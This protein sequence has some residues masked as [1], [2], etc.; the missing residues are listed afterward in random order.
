MKQNNVLF[1]TG[2][3]TNIGKTYAT[4]F[5]ADRLSS[6]GK[7]VITQKL[8]QT[9]CVDSSE[10]IEAHRRLTGSPLIEEDRMGLTCPFIFS[11][12]ASP[13]FAAEIDGRA[14]DCTII[15]RATEALLARGY[16]RVLLEGAGGL[17]VPISKDYLTADFVADRSYPIALVSSGR[18]GSINHTLLNLEICRRRGIAV[19]S[20]I[21]NLYPLTDE[22]IAADT[23]DYL[24]YY[25]RQYHPETEL[26]VMP[27]RS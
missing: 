11:Y 16:D 2:I 23:H 8:V 1:V 3:D 15:D 13:H 5:L 21:Y 6:A 24:D 18:L 20:V 25:L 10:D 9:G 14:V 17:M 22:R 27:A 26:I 7:K 19:E 4:A 12:P